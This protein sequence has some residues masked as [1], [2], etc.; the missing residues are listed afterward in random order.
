MTKDFIDVLKFFLKSLS[1]KE[2]S[3]EYSDLFNDLI[4]KTKEELND[5]SNINCI[6]AGKSQQK[7]YVCS[8]YVYK[9]QPLFVTRRIDSSEYENDIKVDSFTMNVIMQSIMKSIGDQF[10]GLDSINIEHPLDFC[11]RENH[12]IMI[13][14]KTNFGDFQKFLTDEA[15]N[16]NFTDYTNII[17]DILKKIFE[18]NDK[19]YDVCQ[20]QHCDMKCMQ[21]LL[22]KD[23]NDNIIPILSDFDKS[24]CTLKFKGKNYRIRLVKLDTPMMGDIHNKS[25]VEFLGSKTRRKTRK[26]KTRRRK[27]RKKSKISKKKKKGGSLKKYLKR[28]AKKIG[29]KLLHR[30]PKNFKKKFY[31][32]Q[33]L[34]RFKYM[35]LKNNDFYNACLLSSTLLQAR[36]NPEGIL[37]NLGNYNFIDNIN[38]K[39]IN[40]LRDSDK[41]LSGNSVAG[42]C[43]IA[44]NLLE[45]ANKLESMVEV[46]QE[47]NFRKSNQDNNYS[48]NVSTLF[49]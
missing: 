24:T 1:H 14:E 6:K 29:T 49:N 33:G 43:V 32:E 26:R 15:D 17:V 34:Q 39:K 22:N 20:F 9:A 8:Q 4:G 11:T 18:V 41:D 5:N 36:V 23:N 13:Y 7:V 35:P 45:R 28:S 16:Y 46:F 47:I 40:D 27:T 38:L 10:Q 19:L 12:L 21:I 3:Q 2:C 48:I 25:G 31:G 44:D 42:S 30:T 37:Q